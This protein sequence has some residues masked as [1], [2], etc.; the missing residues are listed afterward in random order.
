MSKKKILIVDDDPQ[1]VMMTKSRLEANGYEVLTATNGTETIRM[2]QE[3]KPDLILMDVIMPAMDGSEVC[4]KLKA[5]EG[6]RDIPILM[7]TAY[8]R[9]DL[10]MKCLQAGAKA[11][12]LK[13]FNPTELLALI[14]KAF[15]PNS[16]WR[17]VENIDA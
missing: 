2:T 15:D 13:P 7:L 12:I 8:A 3:S 14:K 11:V 9:K 17:R 10:E 1:V 6:T 5:D 4:M 16:K